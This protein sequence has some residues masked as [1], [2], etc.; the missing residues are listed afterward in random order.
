VTEPRVT[1][2]T[3]DQPW[4]LAPGPT[5]GPAGSP[6]ADGWNGT[7]GLDGFDGIP[8]PP[9]AVG[10]QGLPGPAAVAGEL[11]TVY[12]E[13][14]TPNS[15]TSAVLEDIPGCVAVIVL[16]EPV[17][18][19]AW[20]TVEVSLTSPVQA[21]IGIALQFD[22]TDHDEVHN[23]LASG[24][25]TTIA[26]VHRTN[27]PVAAGAHT[28]KGRFRRVSGVGI[29]QVERFDLLVMA[30]QGAIGP[31]GPAGSPGWDGTDG[32]DGLPGFPGA[33][34]TAGTAGAAGGAG[35]PGLD[36]TDG[37]DSLVPG[38]PGPPGPQGQTGPPGSGGSGGTSMGPPGWDG[39]DGYEWMVPGPPGPA[40]PTLVRVSFTRNLGAGDRSGTFDLT[41]LSGLDPNR[42][43]MVVQTAEPITSKGNARDEPELDPIIATGFVVDATTI[44]VYWWAP[45][46]VVGDYNFA[47][48]IGTTL[49]D[50]G[51][52]TRGDA[53]LRMMVFWDGTRWLSATLYVMPIAVQRNLIPLSGTTWM[54]GAMPHPTLSVWVEDFWVTVHVSTPNNTLNYW[55][56]FDPIFLQ[57]V[58]TSLVLADRPNILSVAV[59]TVFSPD[60]APGFD[61]YINYLRVDMDKVGTP[62]PTAG[63]TAAISYRLIAP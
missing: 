55:Q 15:T 36:G 37:L 23:D 8:G 60:Y 40:G 3:Y 52:P 43:V 24:D 11:T 41:G 2:P 56:F 21:T 19:A 63:V 54:Y 62:G 39:L 30:L 16:A 28:I 31:Q 61:D 1:P 48:I 4:P 35:Q 5:P 20:L 34:G 46:V 33:P 29:P 18:I 17:N 45:S 58:N 53:T 49:T 10:P 12:V 25:T 51:F 7:D 57:E 6:G 59:N 47:Y 32:L 26:L 13:D 42:P 22:G 9:G 38:P 27:A 50:I 14:D 44:R